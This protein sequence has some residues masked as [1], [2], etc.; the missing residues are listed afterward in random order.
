MSQVAAMVTN[1]SKDIFPRLLRF[2]LVLN[3]LVRKSSD[4]LEFTQT[5]KFNQR[6]FLSIELP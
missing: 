5:N 1:K 2:V 6:I 4:L 3:A